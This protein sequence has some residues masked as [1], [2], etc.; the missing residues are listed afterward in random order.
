MT[1]VRNTGGVA[2]GSVADFW[3]ALRAGS[4]SYRNRV[5][6]VAKTVVFATMIGLGKLS[7]RFPFR[8]LDKR[9]QRLIKLL[10]LVFLLMSLI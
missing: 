6:A 9:L 5:V 3:N 7:L 10:N 8:P 2:S 1:T 4:S